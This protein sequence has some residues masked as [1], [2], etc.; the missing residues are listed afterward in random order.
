MLKNVKRCSV[1]ILTKSGINFYQKS[2]TNSK[3]SDHDYSK[4]HQKFQN[5]GCINYKQKAQQL[6]RIVRRR[7]IRSVSK[8]KRLKI[9]EE[10]GA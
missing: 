8:F 3:F 9:Y 4:E 2:V 10:R 6:C 5:L 7:W 1:L